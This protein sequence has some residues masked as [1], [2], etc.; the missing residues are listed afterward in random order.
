M[1]IHGPAVVRETCCHVTQLGLYLFIF[2]CQ[3]TFFF[4]VVKYIWWVLAGVS[5][6]VGA[7][8]HRLKGCRFDSRSGDI[9]NCGFNTRLGRVQKSNWLVFLSH[10]DI[11]LSLSLSSPSP[12]SSLSFS[13]SKSNE[14]M[15]LGEGLNKQ[16]NKQMEF[17]ILTFLGV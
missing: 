3:L 16:T 17:A 10:M 6:L 8:S 11:C 1:G 14:K 2:Y 12:P 4:L 5:Y 9:H 13:V 7:P 15:S